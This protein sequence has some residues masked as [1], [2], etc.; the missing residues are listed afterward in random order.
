MSQLGS[1]LSYFM[2]KSDEPLHYFQ[3][4][5]LLPSTHWVC[6]LWNLFQTSFLFLWLRLKW[7]G[8]EIFRVQIRLPFRDIRLLP[9]VVCWRS[10]CCSAQVWRA[11][12]GF[13][14]LALPDSLAAQDMQLIFSDSFLTRSPLT[15]GGVLVVLTWWSPQQ[16]S[17]GAQPS[18]APCPRSLLARFCS[19]AAGNCG[20]IET[21]SCSGRNSLT[22]DDWWQAARKLPRHGAAD[23]P[24]G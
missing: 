13:W 14:E 9:F 16:R 4:C 7:T 15:S 10:E 22:S 3:S 21:A 11:L 5:M 19:S 1:F 2:Q 20:R 6:P 24:L 18:L 12:H 17:C 23:S 8:T